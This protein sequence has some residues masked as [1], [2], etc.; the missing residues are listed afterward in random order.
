MTPDDRPPLLARAEQLCTQLEVH[1]YRALPCWVCQR[2]TLIGV[3]ELN[4]LLRD[5]VAAVG[6]LQ[7]QKE[8]LLDWRATVTV[9]LGREGGAFFE[10]VPKHIRELKARAEVAE[11]QLQAQQA[12][13]FANWAHIEREARAAGIG[14]DKAANAY[15]A[16]LYTIRTLTT[17]TQPGAAG[18]ETK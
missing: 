5:L 12:R 1:G 8:K 11:A 10:D 4:R 9:S 6:D 13:E 3:D 7:Q 15:E 14:Y 16:A 18:Q 17:L 2:E